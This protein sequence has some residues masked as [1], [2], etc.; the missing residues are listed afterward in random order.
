LEQNTRPGI[1]TAWN[2]RVHGASSDGRSNKLLGDTTARYRAACHDARRGACVLIGQSA[3]F[4]SFGRP[5]ALEP[6]PARRPEGD[7]REGGSVT[8][9][10]RL[11]RCGYA[12]RCKT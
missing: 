6:K 10:S 4:Y 3:A 2:V 9:D 1:V 8:C 5:R 7:N 11:T 12:T